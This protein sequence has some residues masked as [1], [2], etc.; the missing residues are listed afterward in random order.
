MVILSL[1]RKLSK[2]RI[3]KYLLLPNSMDGMAT[4][5]IKISEVVY[6][7][8]EKEKSG[9]ETFDDVLRRLLDLNPDLEDLVAYLPKDLRQRAQDLTDFIESLGEFKIEVERDADD[10]YDHLRFVSMESGLTVA[11]IRFGEEWVMTDYRNRSG[12]M[13][14]LSSFTPDN[15]EDLGLHI[16]VEEGWEEIKEENRKKIEGAY[17]RWG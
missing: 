8:L 9:S 5:N 4:K 16:D 7:T 1:L 14:K 3:E 12:N 17:R 13:E 11:R 10:G 6:D 15:D 2:L